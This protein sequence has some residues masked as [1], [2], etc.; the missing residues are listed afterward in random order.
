MADAAE[1]LNAIESPCIGTCTL[2]SDDL[3]IGCFRS[4]QEIASWLSYSSEQRR[5]II[6][7]LP[8]RAQQ[9]FDD[10]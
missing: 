5:Q 9:L 3:C 7:E 8:S 6:S 1:P 10:G 4:R 2:G